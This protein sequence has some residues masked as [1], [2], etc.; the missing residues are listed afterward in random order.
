[1]LYGEITP[2]VVCFSCREDP[3][4][5]DRA[6]SAFILEESGRQFV[7]QFKYHQCPYLSAPAVRWLKEAGDRFYRWL[8]YDCIVPVPLHPRK[9]R[10]RGFNQSKLLARGLS[11]RSG[12]SLPGKKLLRHR[13][14][15]TQTR[16]K[17]RERIR[18]VQ[19]AFRV[20]D[21]GWLREKSILLVDDVYTTGA[22]VNECA[23]VLKEDGALRVDV[24]TLA[25]AR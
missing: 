8:D 16:L 14:T 6:R 24:L 9:K 10:E 1:M 22:T 11:R 3:P 17:L 23:R 19:G 21:Q 4:F 15:R 12:V 5:F 18:N 25:R 7:W 2:P 20:V 13:Y